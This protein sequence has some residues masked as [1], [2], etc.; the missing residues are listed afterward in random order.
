MRQNSMFIDKAVL[1]N[2][3]TEKLPFG[4]SEALNKRSYYAG[5]R[6]NH[7]GLARNRRLVS[8]IKNVTTYLNILQYFEKEF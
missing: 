1:D 7:M 5:R 6:D 4:C 3:Y 2:F 8:S